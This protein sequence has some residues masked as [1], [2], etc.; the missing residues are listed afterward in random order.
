[1][2]VVS[3]AC[4]QAD[5]VCTES[6]HRVSGNG[7]TAWSSGGVYP[8]ETSTSFR[9]AY[10]LDGL[11]LFL[12]RHVIGASALSCVL[13]GWEQAGFVP[14]LPIPPLLC[15]H[16]QLCPDGHSSLIHAIG[17]SAGT[18]AFVPGCDRATPAGETLQ[19]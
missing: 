1:M 16:Y 4:V 17:S 14:P 13:L 15:C 6:Y 19:T 11:L 18:I 2:H 10:T 9:R 12:G 8:G 3:L 7:V 5:T